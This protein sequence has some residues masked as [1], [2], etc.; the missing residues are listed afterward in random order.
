MRWTIADR[1]VGAA[2]LASSVH[3]LARLNAEAK[4]DDELEHD[5]A[6]EFDLF[7]SVGSDGKGKVVFSAYYQPILRASRVK[8][9]TFRYPL[10][11]KP[12]DLVSVDLSSFG[13]AGDPIVG[14]IQ[15]GNL[16]PYYSRRDIDVRNALSRKGLEL[17][18]LDDAFDRLT[19]HV[20]GS[21]LLE[22]PDGT[23][24]VKF[25]ATN[26]LPFFSVGSII[27]GAGIIPRSEITHERL[28][29]Y[30]DEHPEGDSWILSQDARYTFFDLIP[31]EPG[32]EP[33]GLM[34]RPLTPGRSIAIDPKIV[35]LGAVAYFE[36]MMPQ[37]DDRGRLLGTF[38]T[39]R[40]ALCQDTG[41][42]IQGPGRV[43]IFIGHG[44]Q[45]PIMAAHQ[46]AEGKLYLLIRKNVRLSQTYKG[47]RS[48]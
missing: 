28:R 43:D 34:G 46:W 6:E 24:L 31:Q 2:D 16:V 47:K 9:Q 25:A 38:Q 7:E 45:A 36:T 1:S 5:L 37:V 12:H 42:A 8:T 22:F 20:E 19:L 13:L 14:R 15:K 18:W 40:F 3:E 4:D 41:G 21:G 39:S 17:A 23:S 32:A 27:V 29:Q 44:P 33:V 30:L 35:P 26:G 10:Y 11:S 48:G